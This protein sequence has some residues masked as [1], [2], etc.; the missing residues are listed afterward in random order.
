MQ[1]DSKTSPNNESTKASLPFKE[2][3]AFGAGEFT[4]RYG[5]NGVNDIATPV[6]NMILGLSPALI[7]TVLMLMRLW[8]AITDP[9]MGYVSDN[10]KGKFG[11]R[12]PFLF[13][14]SI[15][16]AIVYPL[17]WFASP[18]WTEQSKTIYFFCLAIIFF[19]SYTIYSVPF[20]ALA[21]EMTP[22][23]E[24]RT[25]IRIYSAFFN[26]VFML[27][28]PWIFP[29]TQTELFPD[30]VTG[31]RTLAGASSILIL[32]SGIV[33]SKF[34]KE[35]YHK[36]AADQ[37]RVKLVSSFKSFL[38]DR[39]FLILHGVGLGLLCSILLVATFGLY[40]NIYYV[41]GGDKLGGS[42]YFAI[43]Q[44][45]MQVL[46]FVML[47]LISKYLIK[48]EKRKLIFLSL[49]SAL[50]GT[51]ARWFTYNTDIPQLIFLDPFFFAPAYTIFWAIFLSMLGDY[52]DYD[53]YTHGQR[54][55]GIFSAISG[56]IMKAGSSI[57]FG[58]SGILLAWT[59]FSQELGS[60]QPEGTLLKMRLLLIGLPILCLLVAMVLNAR[61]PL[62]KARMA[63]IRNELEAR[64]G[65]V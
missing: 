15:L 38:K 48:V 34:P 10:W 33:C 22:D 39:N 65:T 3:V 14:G 43:M 36:V 19:T 25:T 64:R 54:R 16:M 59:H 1:A 2:K 11:R 4:N 58:V 9:I 62:T 21:T 47:F 5:E 12:K 27:M 61:Y 8:D 49:I 44:N 40:V 13:V 60:D 63:N 45:I 30:P 50:V 17:I 7:G 57:A 28:L 46:G 20:R 26:K 37:E 53:E 56:W 23:Y 55:E 18:D 42:S 6:Y 51:L 32:I 35:R 52:C 31:I 41:W 24:E 29:L